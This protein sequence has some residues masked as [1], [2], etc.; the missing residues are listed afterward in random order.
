VKTLVIATRNSHKVEE[1]RSIL[2]KRYR[3]LTLYDFPSAPMLVEDGSTFVENA[4]KKAV[5][6][7]HWLTNNPKILAMKIGEAPTQLYVL[8]DDSGLEVDALGGAPGVHSARFAALDT[9]IGGNSPD[10]LNNLKLMRLMEHVPADKRGARFHCVI[11]VTKIVYGGIARKA[12]ISTPE[13]LEKQTQIH[14][15]TCEGL[16]AREA[17]GK[18]GFGYD[19]YFIPS[20]Y[21]ATYAELS[22]K[23]KNKLSHRYQALQKVKLALKA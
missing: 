22:P 15:G 12:L 18:G 19:P 4:M 17:A 16:I 1:I 20:G 23:M 8:A 11:A 5:G 7:A 21:G 9:G 13:G 6:L 2:G 10:S 14:E 3:Y